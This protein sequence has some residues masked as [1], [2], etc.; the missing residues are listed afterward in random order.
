[1]TCRNRESADRG[2][3]TVAALKRRLFFGDTCLPFADLFGDLGGVARAARH[4]G[5][6][7]VNQ[8]LQISVLRNSDMTRHTVSNSVVFL[9]M[10]K[11][12]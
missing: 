9:L 5:H 4:Q 3:M 10:F 11:F 2:R 6:V 7:G 1:M 12:E 8:S